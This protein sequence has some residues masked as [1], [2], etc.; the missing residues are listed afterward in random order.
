MKLT[1]IK[2]KKLNKNDVKAL[3]DHYQTTIKSKPKY[4]RLGHG[5]IT[6]TLPQSMCWEWANKCAGDSGGDNPRPVGIRLEP[7]VVKKDFGTQDIAMSTIWNSP[8]SLED[9][10]KTYGGG[11]AEHLAQKIAK[12]KIK[13][14]QLEER[15]IQA[16]FDQHSAEENL[17]DDKLKRMC[18]E[19]LNI[20]IE[21]NDISV[22]KQ[23][24]KEGLDR[25]KTCKCTGNL[26]E[27]F[28]K[29]VDI[30]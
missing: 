16:D 20:A 21:H 12:K 27:D 19:I 9:C 15:V 30:V 11:G 3:W 2:N 10:I 24:L 13:K 4:G 8:Q 7:G 6:I 23:I 29:K 5:G 26:N 14:D 25:F 22:I 1:L 18:I 17:E 28:H